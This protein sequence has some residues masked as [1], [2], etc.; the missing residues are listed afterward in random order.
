MV[1]TRLCLA[2]V[3]T[4]ICCVQ[5]FAADEPVSKEP[6]AAPRLQQAD[7]AE[8]PIPK[9]KPKTDLDIALE[10]LVAKE[11]HEIDDA[12]THHRVFDGA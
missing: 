8:K 9:P 11:S 10:K 5:V 12:V 2:I 6:A 1:K 7:T 4:G 3:V